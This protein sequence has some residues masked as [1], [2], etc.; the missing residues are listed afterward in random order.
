MDRLITPEILINVFSR[1]IL[2]PVSSSSLSSFPFFEFPD[3][4]SQIEEEIR[5]NINEK[6]SD[7]E[8][9]EIEIN[10]KMGNTNIYKQSMDRRYYY[11]RRKL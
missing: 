8:N 5:N 6:G 3:I 9:G 2:Y 10:N 11:I 7:E 1:Y 4:M